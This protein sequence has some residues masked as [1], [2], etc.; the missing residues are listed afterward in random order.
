[1]RLSVS[2]TTAMSFLLSLEAV[3]LPGSRR[4][5]PNPC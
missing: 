5:I 2:V 3:A 1:M 4:V